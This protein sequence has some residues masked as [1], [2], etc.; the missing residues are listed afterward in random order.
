MKFL[1]PQQYGG[2]KHALG[3]FKINKPTNQTSF[4]QTSGKVVAPATFP[5]ARFR[6]EGLRGLQDGGTAPHVHFL[7]GFF[8]RD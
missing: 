7:G 8:V 2:E 3:I 1:S 4:R 6:D 5:G